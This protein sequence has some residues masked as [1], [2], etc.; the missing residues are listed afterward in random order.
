MVQH[1]HI[2]REEKFKKF[3]LEGIL[4]L[5]ELAYG[6]ELGVG[7][8]PGGGGDSEPGDH[9]GGCDDHKNG[10]DDDGQSY[11]ASLLG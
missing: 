2:F 7:G 8:S 4:L 5:E 1:N 9:D 6:P 10:L 3:H 11:L